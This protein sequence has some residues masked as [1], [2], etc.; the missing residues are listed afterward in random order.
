MKSEFIVVPILMSARQ[1]IQT[2]SI[3]DNLYT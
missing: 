2:L 3:L 1:N